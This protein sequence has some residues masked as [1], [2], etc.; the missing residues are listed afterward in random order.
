MMNHDALT[1]RPDR[2]HDLV[3]EIAAAQRALE[4]AIRSADD[5]HPIDTAHYTAARERLD[6]AIA[7]WNLRAGSTPAP[8]TR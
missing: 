4:R 3:G 2:L 7:A 6:A 5:G 8:R 1:S